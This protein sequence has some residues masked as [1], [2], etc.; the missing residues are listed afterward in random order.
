MVDLFRD[1]YGI[2]RSKAVAGEI[3]GLMK[4]MVSRGVFSQLRDVPLQGYNSSLPTKTWTTSVQ[5]VCQ[6][7]WQV[8]S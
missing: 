5:L 2:L 8:T 3:I 6:M 4:P 1:T 7:P